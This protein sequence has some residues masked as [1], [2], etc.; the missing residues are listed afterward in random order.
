[1]PPDARI[2]ELGSLNGTYVNGQ[3]L[4]GKRPPGT[5]PGPNYGASE[6]DL[7]DGATVHL[8]SLEQVA[9]QVRI[10]TPAP[11]GGDRAAVAQEEVKTC[12][13]CH[14][15]VAAQ[16]GANRPGLFVCGDCRTNMQAIMQ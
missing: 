13:W 11:S 1:N 16:R 6:M 5:P 12:A 14:R 7:A 8:T 10:V 2:R 15:E 3:L 9:F 4:P